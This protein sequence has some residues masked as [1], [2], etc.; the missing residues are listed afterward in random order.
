MKLLKR[1]N[2]SGRVEEL[3]RIVN[4]LRSSSDLQASTVLARLRL[5][6]RVEEVAKS[7][8]VAPSPLGPSKPP[9]L[10]A[11]ESTGTSG[12]GVSLDSTNALHEASGTGSLRHGS[13]VSMT[14]STG[15]RPNWPTALSR[16]SPILGASTKGKQPINTD[17]SDS[18]AFLSITFDREDFLLAVSESDDESDDDDD[19][20]QGDDTTIS[21]PVPNP[22]M[23]M[24]PTDSS[25]ETRPSSHR[26]NTVRSIYATHLL[27]RQPIV[28]TIIVHPNLNLRNL[29]GNMPFS[30]SIQTN[31]FPPEIQ[32]QQIS[33]L[34]LPTWSMLP[35][36]TR[37]DPGSLRYVV[38]FI[39][40]E[41]TSMIRQGTMVDF[42]IETHPNIAALFDEEEFKRSGNT[43]TCF[44]SMYLFW[45]LIRWMISPSEE[46]YKAMPEWLRPTPN[47]LFMPHINFVDFVAW[48]AF[49]ELV[50]QIPTMQ[51]RMEWLMDMS[52]TLHCDW[53]FPTEE[54]LSRDEETG[55]LDLCSVAKE[56][57]RDL[58]NWS[59]APSFRG[60]VSNADTYVRIRT[61]GL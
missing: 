21:Y 25:R 19:T 23:L 28:N 35:V 38:P 5:G 50:V 45:Y 10:L 36:N 40:E 53:S 41:A 47:Q 13:I 58:S 20:Y 31:H 11:Q 43:F 27:S 26:K 42:V 57:M 54:A 2:M 37:P 7:L 52:Q 6:E 17:D 46:T 1:D 51:E 24:S 8:P 60:Y 44:A 32:T 48:P 49:R 61:E 34:A 18:H 4:F 16:A 14:S 9:S 29:F 12:S 59:V 39:L 15:H 33:N 30:S 56:T 55:L 22:D 3:E